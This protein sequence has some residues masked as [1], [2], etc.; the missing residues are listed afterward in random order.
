MYVDILLTAGASELVGFQVQRRLAFV[1]LRCDEQ[2]MLCCLLV[3]LSFVASKYVDVCVLAAVQVSS[4]LA[5][6]LLC[7]LVQASSIASQNAKAIVCCARVGEL[8]KN[9]DFIL[10]ASA[11][12][13][14][15][16]P[17]RNCGFH[18]PPCR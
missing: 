7:L 10:S 17:I 18:L 13:L 8:C 12:E 4:R 9:V 14:Y 16:F 3:Q 1:G 5:S 11:R 15:S 6:I 2:A